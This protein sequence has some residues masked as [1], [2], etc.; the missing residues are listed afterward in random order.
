[1]S[2]KPKDKSMYY[3][4]TKTLS[5]QRLFN[6]VVGARGCGKT[7]GCK[8]QVIN[9]FLRKNEQFVYLRRY[10]TEF[11][12]AEIRN[13]F[14]DVSEEF[15]EHEFKAWN[16][17]FRIDDSVAGWYFALSKAVML[18]SI[19]FPNV[20]LIIFDEFI[21]E[22]GVYRYL[23]NEVRLFLDCYNTISRD[24]D[25]PVL[26]MSNAITMA[27]PYFIYFNVKFE[28]DQTVFL[29]PF[30]SAEMFESAKYSEHISSTKFGQLI[31]N[32]EY[33]KYAMHNKFLLD[34]DTFIEEMPP[35]CSYICTMIFSGKEVG[36]YVNK[37]ASRWY[38]SGKTD[39]TCPRKFTLN[40]TEHTEQTQLTAKNNLYVSSMLNY[41]CQ[42][43]LRFDTQQTKNVCNSTLKKL[44]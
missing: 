39:S 29:T 7:Y 43:N 16:G 12:S 38:L 8:K 26:F 1:M 21:I 20:S 4:I 3:D 32:T 35:G 31:A 18:K 23:P 11:P 28:K 13:F 9:N 6:F 37:E 40:L 33:G 19:P 2:N 5:K 27:N 17:I 34:T 30:I 22:T 25:V 10:E 15:P 14:D 24:R 41:F 36:F 42:G 44:L